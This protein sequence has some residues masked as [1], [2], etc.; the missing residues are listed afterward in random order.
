VLKHL[1]LSQFRSYASLDL[2]LDDRVLLILGPNATGKTNILEAMYVAAT[3][4]SFRADDTELM[5]HGA[6]GFRVDAIHDDEEIAVT[7]HE[8]PRKTKRFTRDAVALTR[9]KLLGRHPIVLFEP[10]DL[11]LLSGPPE[12]RRRYL[13]GV[14]LQTDEVYQREFLAW[15]RLL[16]QRNA[17]LW[18][19]KRSGVPNLDDQLFILETQMA[20]VA[21]QISLLRQKLLEDIS[22]IVDT[23]VP[24]IAQREHAVRIDFIEKSSNFLERARM[25]RDRDIAI[26]STTIG[27]HREDWVVWYD[28]H[29]LKSTASR[30]E[31]RTT[32]LALKLA[33]LTYVKT[34]LAG[35]TPLLLLDDVFSELDEARRRQLIAELG[36]TQTVITST[37]IDRRLKLPA[38][39]LNLTRPEV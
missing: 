30:G 2:T 11:L 14:L 32:L 1:R 29:P 34:Q 6:D 12:R 19:N 25:T 5:L 15:R 38:Q 22:V 24:R 37:D 35:T 8:A 39:T 33:E 23:M 18:R 20:A 31:V 4:R 26:G 9:G 21:E 13:D 27:P 10:N 3:G 28:D 16:K 17:L 7:Y 36:D